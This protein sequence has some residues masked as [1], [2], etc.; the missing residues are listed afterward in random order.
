MIFEGSFCIVSPRKQ[1]WDFLWNVE[2]ISK[3]VPG[4]EKVQIESED[5]YTVLVKTK[6]GFLSARFNLGVAILELEAPR[7]VRSMVEGKDSRIAS[8]VKLVNKMEL[9]EISPFETEVRYRSD[10]TLMGKLATLGRSIIKGKA[11][12][13]TKEFTENIKKEIENTP[14]GGEVMKEA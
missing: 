11:K 14:L 2:R 13:L 10:I 9:V 3:C 7:W 8:G 6:V 12:Q 5:S 1:V 4:V